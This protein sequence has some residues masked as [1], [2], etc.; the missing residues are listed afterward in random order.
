ME[1]AEAGK[2][3]AHKRE[4]TQIYPR[5]AGIDG[6]MLQG[7]QVC[8]YEEDIQQQQM[9]QQWRSLPLRKATKRSKM[10]KS[11]Q[12]RTNAKDHNTRLVSVCFLL[13]ALVAA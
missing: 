10:P 4:M 6:T 12:T 1:M 13:C 9:D 11:K 2:H 7:V 3:G 8:N 5:R